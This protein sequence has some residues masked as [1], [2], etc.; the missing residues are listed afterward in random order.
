ML[1]VVPS[2]VRVVKTAA[3]L[4]KT[5]QVCSIFTGQFVHNIFY[6]LKLFTC[7]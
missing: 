4:L 6:S 1:Q 2:T 7:H 3:L 5:G